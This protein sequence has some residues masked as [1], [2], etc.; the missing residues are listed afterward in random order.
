MS[1]LK[2]SNNKTVTQNPSEVTDILNRLFSCVGHQKLANNIPSSSRHFSDYFGD[3]VYPNSFF[4]DPV[5]SSEIE[6]E[7]LLTPLNKLKVYGLYSC[8]IRILKRSNH[9]VSATLAET[10]NMSVQ[11]GFYP[12]K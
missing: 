4:F 9:I 6:S 3:Q 1:A 7:I 5:T 8:P 11:T 10:M 2:R 12:S